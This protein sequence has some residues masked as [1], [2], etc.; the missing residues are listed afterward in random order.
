MFLIFS[1]MCLF[2]FPLQ[3]QANVLDWKIWSADNKL[4]TEKFDLARSEY[5]QIQTKDPNNSRLNYNLGIANYR[6]GSMEQAKNS[7]QLASIQTENKALKQKSFYNLGNAQFMLQDYQS[8][9]GSY[10]FALELDPD[11]EDAKHNLELARK[12]IEEQQQDKDDNNDDNSQGNNN[13]DNQDSEDNQD[14][15]GN[16]K[17]ENQQNDK[18][19]KQG[20]NPQQPKPQPQNNN[21]DRSNDQTRSG[22]LSE[23]DLER[24][25]MQAEEADPS[26]VNQNRSL[27]KGQS[28]SKNLNPW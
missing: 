3:A 21:K 13:G 14:G 27:N 11:D 1:L 17:Q 5:L 7:F 6:L 26:E 16:D 28:N 23:K 8:A 10:E 24:M 22:G 9:I 2:F 4:K 18:Q 20:Q 15:S 25:L 19:D 12:K